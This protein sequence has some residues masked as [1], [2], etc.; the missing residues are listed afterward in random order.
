MKILVL[1]CGSSS[2][3]YQ[4]IEVSEEAELL[5]KGLLDRIGLP[6]SELIHQVPGKEKYKTVQEVPDHEVGISLIMK[7]LKDPVHGVIRDEKEIAAV[8]HRVAHGGENFKGSVRITESVKKDIERCGELAPLHN[9][10]NLKGILSI[11]AILPYIPQ[12]AVFDTSFHQTM[13]LIPTFMP[14]P[15]SYMKNIKSDDTD[16][17]E[18]LINISQRKLAGF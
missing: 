7:T 2:V 3:K 4:L 5:C 14:Y 9:P 11:E 10:A 12:V 16:F 1:N 8:G 6:T 18:L 17:T 15:M 13:P